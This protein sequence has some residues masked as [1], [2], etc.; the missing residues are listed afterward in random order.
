MNQFICSGD[1]DSKVF[2]STVN[3]SYR[4]RQSFNETAGGSFTGIWKI[5][6]DIDQN[7]HLAMSRPGIDFVPDSVGN[8]AEK[9]HL[10]QDTPRISPRPYGYEV[11]IFTETPLSGVFRL[12][13]L[14]GFILFNFQRLI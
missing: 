1:L 9:N 7:R 14:T 4:N 13:Y 3:Q 12:L 6:I 11:A 10:L 2:R 5:R 8:F